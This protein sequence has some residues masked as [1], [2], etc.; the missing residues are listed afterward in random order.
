MQSADPMS[1]ATADDSS[2]AT[3]RSPLAGCGILIAAL[4]VM[5]F[6]VGFSIT[7]LFRQFNEIKKFT[8]DKPA[9]VEVSELEDR[10][11]ELNDLA[12][13]L[14]NFRQELQGEGEVSLALSAEDLNLAIAA[15]APLSELRSTFR[16]MEISPEAMRV[17]ISFQLNGKPRRA[18]AGEDGWVKY[19]PRFLN[20]IMVARP[21][22]QREEI[23][24]RVDEIEV[25]GAVVPDEFIGQMSPYRPAQR[26]I[27]DAVLGP[28]MAR[29]T[30]VE[31]A[32]GQLVLKKVPGAVAEN[33]ITRGELDSGTSRL[34]LFFGIGASL[35]L[36]LAG[37]ILFIGLRAK[38]RGGREA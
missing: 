8:S 4:C 20:G 10:E 33:V 28:A 19:D 15:Y 5:I 27:T 18:R 37:L 2:K 32:E 29:V 22:V 1:E 23:L 26:Y 9:P 24:L 25:E 17:A 31:L 7:T 14:E 13:R 3:G 34:F 11:A 12:E 36:V 30:S 16:V 35:F 38:G 6:L 21:E